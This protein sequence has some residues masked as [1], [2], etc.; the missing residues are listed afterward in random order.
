AFAKFFQEHPRYSTV[1]DIPIEELSKIVKYHILQNPWSKNQLMSLDVWGWIDSTDVNNSKPRGFKRETLLLEKNK[2]YG[3]EYGTKRSIHIVDSTETA[4]HRIVITDSRKYAPIF[5]KDYFDIY[6]LTSSDYEFYFGR[7]I[8]SSSD[9][10]F[11]GARIM[12]DEIFAENGFVYKV[13]MV[14]DPL[15][16]GYEILSSGDGEHSYKKF[17]GLINN[18]PEFTYN[19]QK[20]L[21][22]PGAD[23]G[24]A[25]DSLFD[26]G[27]PDLNFNLAAEETSS[28]PG[29]HGL[30]DNVTIRYHHGL[31]APTDKAYDD[32][33]AEYMEGPKQWGSI[34]KAD[35]RIQK[36][37]ARSQLSI[38]P[39]YP[40][41]FNHG[42][43]NGELDYITVD[44]ATIVE[45]TFASNCTFIGVDKMVVPRA[46]KAV[47]GP[48]YLQR[49]YKNIMY[50]IEASGLLPALKK[51]DAD[52]QFFVESDFN[53]GQDSS[54]THEIKNGK[55]VF[56]I[57][58]RKGVPR[59]SYELSIKDMRNLLM[60]HI[61]ISRP[62]GIARKEFIKTLAGNYIIYD[63]VTGVVSG[64]SASTEGYQGVVRESFVPEQISTNADNGTTF[65]IPDWFQFSPTSIYQRILNSYPAFYN[66]LLKAGYA[67]QGNN[68]ITFIGDN[69]IYTVFAPT[70]LAIAESGADTMRISSLR[71][72]LKMHFIR[73]NM[74]FT[75]GN[76]PDG[77]YETLRTDESS[78]PFSTV[79]T[80]IHISPGIDEINF[81]AGD[82]TT[83]LHIE[84]S[85]S[86]N[87]LAGRYTGQGT[88]IYKDLIYNGVIH[89]LDKALVHDQLDTK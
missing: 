28:P 82:G 74:M 55:D 18:F 44:P 46:F 31:I 15:E 8:G 79:F 34:E 2:K 62:K 36:I 11:A 24:L 40:T 61:A 77:Y 59:K 21:D 52:Y 84:E 69:D 50:A 3:V 86:T 25:V 49:G 42:F 60:N 33:M 58:N 88:G 10:Y 43:Y 35:Y 75:D 37:V 73:G 68:R 48:I 7:P 89:T 14:V 64:P 6:K 26:L 9:I 71:S 83:Y 17:L 20:T 70:D 19:E 12:G 78:T 23:Q 13:D 41:D 72:F 22:Q 38:N 45:K 80:K 4:W 57:W 67:D 30:P 87:I 65:D 5:Y 63:N 66:L 51:P 27:F 76:L 1:E 54:L 56:L 85:D 53:T 16:N 47:T 81:K 32:F 29:T 39:V